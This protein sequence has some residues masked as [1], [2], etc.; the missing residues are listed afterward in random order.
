LSDAAVS[1]SA[2]PILL[3]GMPRSG[4]TWLG[5]IFDSHPDVLY[6]HEPDTWQRLTDMPIVASRASRPVYEGR[7]RAFVESLPTMRADRVCGKRPLF[8]KSYATQSAVRRYALASALHKGLA[9]AGLRTDPPTPPQ[10]ADGMDYR[11]AWKS[12]ESLGRLGLMLACLPGARSVH[13]VRHP[14]GYVASVLRGEAAARFDHNAA[15]ADFPIYAMLAETDPARRRGLT[16]EQFRAMPAVERLAWR[17]VI[18]NEVAAEDTASHPRNRILYYEELCASPQVVTEALFNFCALG[19][20]GQTAQFLR[21]STSRS[22]DDY[23]SVFKDPLASAWR[24][25]TELSLADA[26][27]V[28]RVTA[29]SAPA[30]PYFA[31]SPWNR[32][33]AGFDQRG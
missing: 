23:Y 20:N 25:Q 8:P 26:A 27:I 5:K 19:W 21:D 33:I 7:V 24:W 10:P 3:F 2:A 32:A 15:A 18:F 6:R 22:R 14:C 9:R 16:L 31:R 30:W 13:I 1:G 29:E 4:T 12:I 11:L 17:W 28:A